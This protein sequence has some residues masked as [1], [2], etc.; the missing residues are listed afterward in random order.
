MPFFF[1]P[2]WDARVAPLRAGERG[3]GARWDGADPH[4]FDGPYGDYVWAKVAK[5]F[6]DLG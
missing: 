5:V 2:G 1:D 4:L 6:P 3:A